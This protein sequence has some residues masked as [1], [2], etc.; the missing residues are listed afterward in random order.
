MAR[1]SAP[2]EIKSF[3]GGLFTDST[4]L[5]FPDNASLD[6]DNMVLD[7]SGLRSRRLGMDYEDDS[8]I[9]T[10]SQTYDASNIYGHTTYRWDNAGN[11]PSESLLA[12]QFGNEVKFFNLNNSVVSSEVILT[13]AFDAT[14][15]EDSYSYAVVDGILTVVT[16]QKEITSFE[17]NVVDNT[18]SATT[19][20]LEIRDL[21]GVSVTINSTDLTSGNNVSTRPSSIN[22]DHKYNL[23]NQSWATAR[24]AANT[25][26][27]QDPITFFF[28]ESGNTVYPA[29]SDSVNKALYA[30]PN[31]TD[32]R[33]KER[34][35]A[36]DLIAN[37]FGTTHAAKGHYIIDAMERGSSRKTAYDQTVSESTVTLTSISSLAVDR[38]EGGPSVISQYAGRVFYSGFNGSLI[39]GDNRSPRMSSYVLFSKQVEDVGDV[40]RCYQDGDPTSIDEPDLLDTDGGFI[41]LD[42][43]YGIKGSLNLS[44]TLFILAANG[45][46]SIIGNEGAGFTATGYS[47][48][49]ITDRGVINIDS[50]VEVE[51]SFTY[52]SEDGIYSIVKNDFGDWIA[53][54][55][56]NNKIGKF[57]S[58][59]TSTNKVNAQGQY[60]GFD[61]KIRW[62]YNN[63]I[64]GN[65]NVRELVLDTILGAF[66]TNTIYTPSGSTLPKVVG[67]FE[68]NPFTISLQSEF[69]VVGT[70]VVQANAIDVVVQTDASTSTTREIQYVIVTNI[71]T[72]IKYTFGLHKDTNWFDFKSFDGTGVDAP[73]FLLTGYLS[74]GDF[75]RRKQTTYMTVY[76]NKTEDG[77]TTDEN[78]DFVAS[79]QSS[80]LV[81][82]QWDW[83]NDANSNRFSIKSEAYRHNRMYIPT[84]VTDNFDDGH[85]VVVTRNKIRGQG[86]VMSIKFNT[87][88]G[89]DFQL[90]GWSLIMSINTQV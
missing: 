79:N 2:V 4:A 29:N 85:T 45:V 33:T 11:D 28:S 12:V 20:I 13:H 70:N 90:L 56:T 47:V 9:I 14:T 41:R 39:G 82:T 80:I 1:E 7:T 62:V 55:I 76:A 84:D 88:S 86:H 26:T 30:D 53:S 59:I 63:S 87:T 40:V 10:T 60:D 44:D 48:S 19:S 77:Y 6:E 3:I 73:A 23:R 46:W 72:V 17:Y 75:Q 18:I 54:S 61:K 65:T 21:F 16:G 50:I 81:Q 34:F 68:S 89:K 67:I 36:K 27:L 52:W 74:G 22:D 35:F 49:K 57:Y 32:A 51:N 58:E 25:E 24:T 15:S 31:D 83:T 43:A 42:G 5:T 66:Y 37:R 78:G 38:T 71:D 8:S 69:V 64:S